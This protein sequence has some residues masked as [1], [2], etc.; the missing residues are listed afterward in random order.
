MPSWF[1]F[2]PGSSGKPTPFFLCSAVTKLLGLLC[3]T[4]LVGLHLETKIKSTVLAAGCLGSQPPGTRTNKQRRRLGLYTLLSNWRVGTGQV[5][6][7]LL[8]WESPL[9]PLEMGLQDSV[10]SKR[11]N[12]TVGI[13]F[14]HLPPVN[15]KNPQ[16]SQN[17]LHAGVMRTTDHI[18]SHRHFYNLF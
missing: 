13:F 9:H 4:L 17:Q 8:C 10:H 18:Q 14:S 12:E 16:A 1:D 5:A 11:R 6:P 7:C 15:G 2:F 3:I